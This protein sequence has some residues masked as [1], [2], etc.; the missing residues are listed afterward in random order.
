MDELQYPLADLKVLDLTRVM[1]GPYAGR[2]LSDL[3]ADVVKLEPPEGDITRIWGQQRHGLS[4]FYTQQNAGKRNLCV[5]LKTAEGPA[6]VRRLA[7]CADLVLENFRP[8]VM[9]RMGLSYDR[10]A[11]DNPGLIMLSVTGFG[12]QSAEAHRPAYAPVIHAESG[13]LARHAEL[14]GNAPSDPIFSL[15]DSYAALHGVVGLLSALHMRERTGR[16][17]H[18]D[19]SMLRSFLATDD[20]SH[21]LLDDDLPVDRLGGQVFDAAGGPLLISSQWKG[22]WHLAKTH[23]GVT[24]DDGNSLEEK[25]AN[26][27]RAVR[28]WIG[29]YDDRESLKRD[30]DRVGLSWGDVRSG[31]AVLDTP[32]LEKESLYREVDDRGGGLRRVV[33]APYEFSHAESGLRGSAPRRGEH[34]ADVLRSWL[35]MSGSDISRLEKAGVLLAE[36]GTEPEEPAPE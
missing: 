35:E 23:F 1:A 34:N 3:G 26:R 11:A 28:E 32:A 18:V 15:A 33:Q 10:L 2:L 12:Q 7:R 36:V 19:I 30:L 14:D 16:G 21:H 17:Q 25:F 8:G 29:S 27:E 5:D 6:L 9:E 4:G 24:A 22:L 31:A 20:Y 13:Y